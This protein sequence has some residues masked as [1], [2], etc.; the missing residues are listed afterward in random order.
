MKIKKKLLVALLIIGI[1]PLAV[2]LQS[3]VLK[4]NMETTYEMPNQWENLKVLPQDI[5]KDSLEF[6]M[7]GY[8]NALGV[9]CGHCHSPQ[10]DNPRRLDFAADDKFEK[11][12]ARGMI[13]MTNELNA[14]YFQPHFPEPKPD[15]VY[16]VD[17][18]MCHRGT[19]NPE[20]YLSKMQSMYKTFDPDK[21]NRR[22]KLLEQMK[23]GE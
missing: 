7:I 12:M 3:S 1:I 15:Q 5:T 17:C 4:P 13:I 11:Q 20:L 9:N 18:V 6:L 10:K 16:V 14:N 22:E 19:P 2:L 23:K 8:S 21:D